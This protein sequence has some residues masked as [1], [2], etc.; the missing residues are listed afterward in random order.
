MGEFRYTPQS[1][2]GDSRRRA[3]SPAAPPRGPIA[4]MTREPR[5]RNVEAVL[6]LGSTRY[7][8]IHRQAYSVAPVPFKLG[9]RILEKSIVVTK[10]AKSLSIS[11]KKEEAAEYYQELARLARMMWPYMTPVS[12]TRKVLKWFHLLRNPLLR[13]S[14]FEI[15]DVADFFLQGR[16]KSSVQS[17][18]EA[19]SALAREILTS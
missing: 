14:E 8:R 10:L 16:T 9:Q 5:Q 3:A 18:S 7:I 11:G 19:E 2:E 4:T 12:R 13:A 1:R 15:K 6:S 17:L